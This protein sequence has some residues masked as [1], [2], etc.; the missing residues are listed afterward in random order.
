MPA[1]QVREAAA[2]FRGHATIFNAHDKTPGVF[3]PLRT[4]L[5]RIHRQMKKAFDP[6]G[7]FNPG[8]MFPGV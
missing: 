3:A 2:R 8:R 4:P 5:D 1:A 7:V 6:D